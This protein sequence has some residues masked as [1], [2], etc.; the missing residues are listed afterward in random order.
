M[1][2]NLPKLLPTPWARKN[3]GRYALA[4]HSGLLYHRRCPPGDGLQG[5][6]PGQNTRVRYPYPGD[7]RRHGTRWQAQQSPGPRQRPE[8]LH[9]RPLPKP[10]QPQ[11]STPYTPSSCPLEEPPPGPG[12]RLG[13]LP[14]PRLREHP[15]APLPTGLPRLR[16]QQAG[17][18][19][20]LKAPPPGGRGEPEPGQLA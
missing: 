12:L 5:R 2:L 11:A 3:S 1:T 6:P 4:H 16:P 10:L 18:L 20:R 13:H 17:L 14:P 9:P 8:P 7:T 15:R 19:P